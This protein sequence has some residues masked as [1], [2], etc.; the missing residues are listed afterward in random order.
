MHHSLALSDTGEVYSF[1]GE[2]E[3]PPL[4]YGA[5]LGHGGDEEKLTPVVI[6][7]LKGVHSVSAGD[8]TS[9]AVTNDGVVYGWGSG[10]GQFGAG[11]TAAG[12]PMIPVLGMG[13][14]TEYQCVPREYP[15]LQCLVHT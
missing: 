6:P 13:F 5:P 15:R 8:Y 3:G 12:R 2:S 1:G 4:G 7:G 9:F 10:A 11:H 14:T